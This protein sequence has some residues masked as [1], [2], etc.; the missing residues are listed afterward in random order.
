MTD[1]FMTVIACI[2]MALV[3]VYALVYALNDIEKHPTHIRD[4]ETF[5]IDFDTSCIWHDGEAE[6]NQQEGTP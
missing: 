1:R 5:Q 4:T 6:P 2:F 3:L